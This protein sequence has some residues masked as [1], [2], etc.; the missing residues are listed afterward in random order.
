MHVIYQTIGFVQKCRLRYKDN[1]QIVLGFG[2]NVSLPG[3][4]GETT[5]T[6]VLPPLKNHT[7]RM[8]QVIL[9]WMSTLELAALNTFE[10]GLG[11]LC[12][13]DLW[14]CGP[15]RLMKFRSQINCIGGSGGVRGL[16]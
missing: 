9:R 11:Q 4:D 13:E 1:L 7:Y 16:F 15:R 12:P 10:S 14:T 8:Q 6:N 2:G 3:S 5:G